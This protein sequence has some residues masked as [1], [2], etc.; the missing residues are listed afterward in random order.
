MATR[1]ITR[2]RETV[3]N[4]LLGACSTV[5]ILA[6]LEVGV[7]LFVYEHRYTFPSG[8]FVLDPELRHRLT[9]NFSGRLKRREFGT[10]V[11]INRSAMREREI[12]PRIPGGI[13]ILVLG[14]SFTF[15]EGVD[16]S[17]SFSKR[18]ESL[19]NKGR[20]TPVVEVVNAGVPGY[21]TV[22]EIRLLRRLLPEVRAELVIL[23][24][25]VG[26][27]LEGNNLSV[28][29]DQLGLR[30]EDGKIVEAT[31]KPSSNFARVKVLLAH[32]SALYRLITRRVHASPTLARYAY[33]VGLTAAEFQLPFLV[34]QFAKTSS[35]EIEAR[36]QDTNALLDEFQDLC[37]LAGCI[38]S[39]AII[40]AR[41][42]YDRRRWVAVLRKY[43]LD[44]AAYDPHAFNRRLAALAHKYSIK[45]VDLLPAFAQHPRP[46]SLHYILDGHWNAQGHAVAAQNLALYYR[47]EVKHLRKAP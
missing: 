5:V 39:I 43:R 29:F 35:A 18:L 42:Q 44:S 36:W 21:S 31:K 14:D 26:N 41:L 27:D 30:L 17:E 9:P 10:E 23:A 1:G 2:T 6:V 11:A 37:A 19:L 7:R 38:P 47:N 13:R 45:I 34:R 32:Y 3:L 33:Q 22:Q 25:Y 24:F 12:G 28:N 16:A 40:P 20:R 46:E 8:M 4:L 15:G